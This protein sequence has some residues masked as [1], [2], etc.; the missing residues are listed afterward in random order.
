MA[1]ITLATLIARIRRLGAY[2][3]S[4]VFTPTFITERINS[5]LGEYAD[6]LDER[7]EGYRD[8][9]GTVA[10]VSGT[11]TVALPADF[12]K[13]R[14][15]DLLDGTV[16]RALTRLQIKQTYGYTSTGKPTGYLHVGA[17]LELF[18]T[19]N[20]VYTIRLRYV[21]TITVLVAD[22]DTID[23][24]NGWE[25]F[26]IHTALLGMDER[27]ERDTNGR[28]AIIERAKQ[29][30]I[31]AAEDRNTAEPEYVPYPGEESVGYFQ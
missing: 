28:L 23:V 1:T 11:A 9:T 25:D 14:A 31:R 6:L 26:I 8:T 12:L 21:P 17:N 16:Y 3:R 22:A 4:T 2:E 15:I 7:W 24:P 10:T 29:R 13:A 19:P 30:I 18:P 20:A 5:A 27:E